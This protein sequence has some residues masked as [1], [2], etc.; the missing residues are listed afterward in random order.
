MLVKSK[1]VKQE[2]VSRTVILLPLR[3]KWVFSG[4]PNGKKYMQAS[5]IMLVNIS[6]YR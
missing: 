6:A 3:S 1:P 4:W 2:E 5:D